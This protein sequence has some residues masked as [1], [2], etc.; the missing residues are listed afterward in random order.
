MNASYAAI[1]SNVE[2]MLRLRTKNSV[3]NGEKFLNDIEKMLD[4]KGKL[5]LRM[6]ENMVMDMESGSMRFT[7]PWINAQED[8]DD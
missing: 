3:L 2:M 1:H 6:G 4:A 7:T 5:G 8:E